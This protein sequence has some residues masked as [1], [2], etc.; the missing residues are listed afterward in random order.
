LQ[1]TDDNRR[2]IVFKVDVIVD[3]TLGQKLSFIAAFCENS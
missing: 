3:L 1:T 2:H